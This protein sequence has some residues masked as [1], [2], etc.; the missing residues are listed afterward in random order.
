MNS[1]AKSSKKSATP[2][3]LQ[4]ARNLLQES[5]DIGPLTAMLGVREQAAHLRRLTQTDSAAPHRGQ[6]WR[7]LASLLF[8]L[9]PGRP[10]I[11]QRA[12]LFYIPDGKFQMQVFAL[13]DA[14][15]G[16]LAICCEDVVTTALK[17]GLLNRQAGQPSRYQVSGT[18]HAL[19]IEHL[20]SSSE[21]PA[22]CNAMTGWNR[23]A[24]RIVLP[25]NAPTELTDAAELLCALS[26]LRWIEA[27]TKPATTNPPPSPTTKS[28]AKSRPSR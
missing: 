20:D 23:K 24:L 17:A 2:D 4:R 13:D 14:E 5:P 6:T 10:R 12:T 9:A 7:R 3:V 18:P 28:P 26:S 19:P 22:Y 21:S 8:A 27:P 16:T 11:L 25:A 15:D 1:Q